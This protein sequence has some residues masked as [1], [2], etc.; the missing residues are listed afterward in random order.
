MT[1]G[2][3]TGA[4]FLVFAKLRGFGACCLIEATSCYLTQLLWIAIALAQDDDD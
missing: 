1:A 4:A 3:E 2:L